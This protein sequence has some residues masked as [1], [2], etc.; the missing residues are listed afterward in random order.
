V[1]ITFNENSKIIGFFFLIKNSKKTNS[2]G[3]RPNI[4]SGNIDLKGT[5]LIPEKD[6]L[7]N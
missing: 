3:K 6:D 2:L 4:R 1:K 5:I 7:R